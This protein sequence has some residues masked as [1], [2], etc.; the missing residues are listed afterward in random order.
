MKKRIIFFIT[1]LSIFCFSGNIAA[2]GAAKTEITSVRQN[3][4]TV[5][6]TIESTKPFYVGGN[7]HILHIGNKDFTR[8]K[9]TKKDGKG[10]LTFLIPLAEWN[11]LTDGADMWMTYGN[12]FKISPD[13]NTDIK[14]LCAKS[15]SK[16]W[17]LNKFS[18]GLLKK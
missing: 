9:Q 15:P 16:C 2:Q 17:Y 13:Q 5:E 4:E 8:S 7:V 10:T 6:F 12:L 3:A 1:C 18:A 14:S 11:A